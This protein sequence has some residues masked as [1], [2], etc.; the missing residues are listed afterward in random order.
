[1]EGRETGAMTEGR[2]NPKMI[3]VT[4]ITEITPGPIQNLTPSFMRRAFPAGNQPGI[5]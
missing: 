2:V 4:P 5:A 3:A 1:V